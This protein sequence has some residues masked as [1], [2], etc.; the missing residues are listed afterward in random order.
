MQ[1]IPD[2]VEFPFALGPADIFSVTLLPHTEKYICEW[3][4]RI[5]YRQDGKPTFLDYGG[6]KGE[7]FRTASSSNYKWK[8]SGADAGGWTSA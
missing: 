4:L 3:Q 5:H 6:Q 1:Q 2:T 7:V 8:W